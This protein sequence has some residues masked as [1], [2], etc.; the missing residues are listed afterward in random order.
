MCK[1]QQKR[2][3]ILRGELNEERE[4]QIDIFTLFVPSLCLELH[5]VQPEPPPPPSRDDYTTTYAKRAFGSMC[6]KHVMYLL[7]SEACKFKKCH[8]VPYKSL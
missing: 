4:V 5:I 1:P 7:D 2:G 3:E 8:I 6:L